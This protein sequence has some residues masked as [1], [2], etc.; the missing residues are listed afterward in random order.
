MK[1]SI[2][3]FVKNKLLKP[4]AAN[5]ERKKSK[6]VDL[7]NEELIELQNTMAAVSCIS[8]TCYFV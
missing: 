3:M 5:T 4:Q 6:Y 7:S 8:L 1:A 2:P